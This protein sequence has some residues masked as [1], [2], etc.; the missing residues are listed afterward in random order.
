L[1]VV[2]GNDPGGGLGRASV[3]GVQEPVVIA[4]NEDRDLV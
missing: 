3:A 4:G 1:R 2:N